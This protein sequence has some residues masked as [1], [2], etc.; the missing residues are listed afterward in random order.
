MNK[1][2]IVVV[3][4]YAVVLVMEIDL[5]DAKVLFWTDQQWSIFVMCTQPTSVMERTYI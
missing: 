3:I 5:F 2:D 1:S 4:C